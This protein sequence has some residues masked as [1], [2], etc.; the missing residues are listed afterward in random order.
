MP[1]DLLQKPRADFLTIGSHIGRLLLDDHAHRSRETK[2]TY[3][4]PTKSRIGNAVRL[5]K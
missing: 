4:K 2:R 1:S 5:G 3:Q